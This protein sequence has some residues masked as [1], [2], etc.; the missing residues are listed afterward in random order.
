VLLSTKQLRQDW[1]TTR[2]LVLLGN[3]M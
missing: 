1:Q 2:S 3:A